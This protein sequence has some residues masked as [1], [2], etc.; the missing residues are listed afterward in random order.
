MDSLNCR[1]YTVFGSSW[2]SICLCG[3][4]SFDVSIDV[5]DG[6]LMTSSRT[7]M[8]GMSNSSHFAIMLSKYF[9]PAFSTSSSRQTSLI[10]CCRKGSTLAQ[11]TANFAVPT[12][13]IFRCFLCR[14]KIFDLITDAFFLL[15]YP[16]D[17]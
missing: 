2:K 6:L 11:C 17:H 10:S 5:S 12:R 14:P 13:K 7:A 8:S 9:N 4:G 1:S 15:F 3:A 16:G